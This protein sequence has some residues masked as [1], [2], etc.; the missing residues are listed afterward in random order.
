MFFQSEFMWIFLDKE[1]GSG[2]GFLP[3]KCDDV[4]RDV[5]ASPRECCENGDVR[6]LRRSARWTAPLRLSRCEH[7]TDQIA[8]E[9]ETRD[10]PEVRDEPEAGDEHGCTVYGLYDQDLTH[11]VINP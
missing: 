11:K 3:W 9:P 4:E 10:E 5:T 2:R 7:P 8:M 6:R 1:T